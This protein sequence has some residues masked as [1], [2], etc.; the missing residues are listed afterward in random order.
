[1][2]IL[3]L[4]R[5]LSR[6]N[7]PWVTMLLVASNVLV[8]FLFQAGDERALAQAQRYYQREELGRFEVPAY[9]RYLA[10]SGSAALRKQWSELPARQRGAYV[11]MHTLSDVGFVAAMREG[12]LFDDAD[13]A[14]GWAQ[15][16]PGYDRLLQRVFTLRHILRSSEVDPWRMLSAAFLHGG[17]THLLGNMLFL[18][19]L[20]VL[21]EGAIG[22]WRYLGVY[23]LGAVGASAASLAW[24]WGEPGG[25]LGASGAIAALMGAFC[26]VWGRQP[27]RFFYWFWVVFDYVKAP[28]IALLPLWLG[29]EVFNLLADDEQGIGFDAHA[30]G[31][32]SGALL[33]V[34]LVMLRQVRGDFIA[35]A[36]VAPGDD[37]WQRAQTHL[38]RMESAQAEAL[39]GELAHEQPQRFDVAMA[40]YR[41]ARNAGQ[42]ATALQRA[43]DVL[44]LAP[45]DP[46]E[47]RGQAALAAELVQ[48]GAALPAD[49]RASL[50]ERWPSF[51][52]V[53]EAE[54]LLQQSEA[55]L[56]E[57]EQARLWFR[58]AL[59][60]GEQ[61]AGAQQR[62]LLELVSARFPRQPQADKA[63]FLLEQG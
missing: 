55:A 60:H 57:A 51:G 39:L 32:L 20:G 54:G 25:G 35:D 59:A 15:R 45:A 17:V 52:L 16:R 18:V 34:V 29:W 56:A 46:A 42:A 4:H 10:Q 49:L 61:H 1:M 26:V 13:Q 30:G 5:P 47:V 31:L 63:R 7:F 50:I 27:V 21:L 38:G 8:F 14:Q 2:L 12:R 3:P 44:R 19:A 11:A 58:L 48:A 37:R 22:A 36:A 9:A 6:E 43:L 23:L 53:R 28:A 40:R 33:G 62:R 41:L 24:R